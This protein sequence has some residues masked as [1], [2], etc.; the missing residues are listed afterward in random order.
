MHG[1]STENHPSK[2][3]RFSQPA[4]RTFIG[5]LAPRVGF[6]VA[7]LALESLHVDSTIFRCHHLHPAYGTRRRDGRHLHS[8]D[9]SKERK[10][11]RRPYVHLTRACFLSRIAEF[12]PRATWR[13][14]FN[15]TIARATAI[16]SIRARG[17]DEGGCAKFLSSLVRVA[18]S[19]QS[20][21]LKILFTPHYRSAT[22]RVASQLIS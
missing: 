2:V 4:A 10:L 8:P 1:K 6:K 13:S 15:S 5:P 18:T 16:D 7:T 12:L 20:A 17:A 21:A 22:F 11:I 14:P 19:F 9:C 3:A